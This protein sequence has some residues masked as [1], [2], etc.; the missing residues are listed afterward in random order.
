MQEL[1]T[2]VWNEVKTQ[3]EDRKIQ[4]AVHKLN[5][6]YVDETLIRHVISN[7]LINAAK[8]TKRKEVAVIEVGIKNDED[9]YIYYV[10]DNGI[11]FNQKYADKMFQVF[12]RLHS[13][14]EFEGTG[15]GLAI[16][17]RIINMHGGK[18]WA[19]GIENE[20]ATIYFTIDTKQHL[21]KKETK[22]H[23]SEEE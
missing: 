7:L 21:E 10:K 12:Q 22:F 15:I 8:F 5:T 2:E 3:Y 13:E 6:A 17:H 9:K 19:E 16:V 11:G 14:K 20:S 23:D 1:F 4:F 18:V